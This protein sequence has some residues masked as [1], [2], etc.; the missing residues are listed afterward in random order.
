[1]K[2]YRSAEWKKYREKILLLDNYTCKHCGRSIQDGVTLHVH[3]TRYLDGHA[4]W[5]YPFDMCETLCGGCHAA[6][7]G[8]I[9]PKVGWECVGF[10][11]LG[12]LT[13]CC[14]LCGTGIRYCFLI[15]HVKWGFLEVGELCC[16]NLT[17]T[18][19]ASN[20]MESI[21]R[22]LD[23]RKRFVS[24]VRWNHVRPGLWTITQDK[25]DVAIVRSEGRYQIKIAGRKGKLRFDSDVEAK[26]A[27]FD[28][29]ESGEVRDW[30][31]K[32]RAGHKR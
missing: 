29:L 14:E 23:R 13:G 4:P 8:K 1:M 15:H 9:P 3:H 26:A 19:L 22:F 11:D 30:L 21:R 17:C 31:E 25:V 20:H 28:R 18:E 6:E 16:D 27:V 2:S 32:Q 10:D 7:H 24:S 12:D 5:E